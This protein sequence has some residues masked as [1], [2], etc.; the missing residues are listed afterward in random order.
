MEWDLVWIFRKV[1]ISYI[2]KNY[3]RVMV[4][5]GRIGTKKKKNYKAG[6]WS[7][8]LHS[9]LETWKDKIKDT[10]REPYSCMCAQ[11]WRFKNSVIKLEISKT[12]ACLIMGRS[13]IVKDGADV[14]AYETR[15]QRCLT[16]RD[17]YS[18]IVEFDIPSLIMKK[19]PHMVYSSFCS[20]WK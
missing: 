12:V 18:L 9:N 19:V 20:S 6:W 4:K 15:W 5:K 14:H 3:E 10:V 11:S 13:L 1:D 8:I 16:L 7:K 17:Q 2:G